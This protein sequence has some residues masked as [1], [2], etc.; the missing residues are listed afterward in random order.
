MQVFESSETTG[1]AAIWKLLE[2]VSIA[3]GP[4]SIESAQAVEVLRAVAPE[5]NGALANELMARAARHALAPAVADFLIESDLLGLMP[6][7]MRA[8]LRGSLHWNSYRTQVIVEEALRIVDSFDK[9]GVAMVCNKGAVFQSSLYGGRATRF[10]SD[11]DIMIKPE[12]GDDTKRVL[13]SLDYVQAKTYD[14][15]TRQL[16]DLPRAEML[17]YKLY[18]DHLPHFHRLTGL[19]QLPAIVVD[20]A[21]NAAWY[22]SGWQIPMDEVMADPERVPAGPAAPGRTLPALAAPYGFLFLVLHLFRE[23]WF[24]RNIREGDVRLTQF[25]DVLLHWRRFGSARADDIRSVIDRYGLGSAVAWVCHHV[26]QVY[27]SSL[28]A[29]IG[30]LDGFADERWFA[31]AGAAD[32]SCLEWH[33]DMRRRLSS[34]EEVELSPTAEPPF[35]AAARVFRD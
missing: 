32:G 21:Y 17:M 13:E 3:G 7:Q 27:G 1:Q 22:G 26:D 12:G 28:T 10:F 15:R 6:N 34:D 24:E 30:G 31:S 18:P 19:P 20:V 2:L 23:A 35:A 33:G 8:H 9:A 16:K 14:Y 5:R 4:D 25:A 11:I 29:E